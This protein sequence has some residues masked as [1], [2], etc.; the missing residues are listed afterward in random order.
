MKQLLNQLLLASVAVVLAF[1]PGLALA[2]DMPLK[3]PPPPLSP[4][5]DWSGFYIGINGGYGWGT[6]TNPAISFT[7][8]GPLFIGFPGYFA[9]GGNVMPNL[10][11][12]GF[13]GGGQIGYD[14]QFNNIVLGIVA[15]F[16]GANINASAT[17]IVTPLGGLG[18]LV[19]SQQSLSEK[20]DFLGTVRAKAG[21]AANN[22]L[23]YGTGGFAYGRVKE[24]ISF[25]APAAPLF[26][27]NSGSTTRGGW[28]GGAGVSYGWSNWELGVEWMHYDLG[29]VSITAPTNAPGF[30]IPGASI[31]A[32]E[33]VAGNVVRGVISYKF[34]H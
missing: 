18:P 13:I 6:N 26:L 3:A 7:D 14:K 32:S 31:T 17:N 12:Q 34:G 25:D 28:A 16:D 1:V 33:R 5:W 29:R 19:T 4:V 23:F 30:I 8:P 21:V 27:D 9:A 10:R 22:W 20:L 2:A 24:S 15:D 11:P